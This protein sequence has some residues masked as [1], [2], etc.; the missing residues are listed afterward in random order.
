VQD[1]A[2]IWID[3]TE[4]PRKTDEELLFKKLEKEKAA[5]K[6]EDKRLRKEKSESFAW[7]FLT[8]AIDRVPVTKEILRYLKYQVLELFKG[9]SQ[10]RFDPFNLNRSAFTFKNWDEL[11]ASKAFGPIGPENAGYAPLGVKGVTC[12]GKSGP[13]RMLDWTATQEVSI[14][15]RKRYTPEEIIQ[16]LRTMRVRRMWDRNRRRQSVRQGHGDSSRDGWPLARRCLLP[17]Q[18]DSVEPNDDKL[19]R[20]LKR[21][22]KD[23]GLLKADQGYPV[24][25][26]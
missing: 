4:H 20:L 12:P 13:E 21:M 24:P 22:L 6:E 10:Q 18:L 9:N 25:L 16:H 2:G 19:R 1:E 8:S 3:G 5:R 14:M 7:T 23:V 17:V 15:P 11:N 26:E